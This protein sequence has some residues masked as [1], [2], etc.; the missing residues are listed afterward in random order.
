MEI[1]GATN[2]AA[3]AAL[4]ASDPNRGSRFLVFHFFAPSSADDGI[5]SAGILALGLARPAKATA[6][7]GVVVDNDAC[8]GAWDSSVGKLPPAT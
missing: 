2:P 3:Q 1:I 4:T 6:M 7:A 5:E 8:A